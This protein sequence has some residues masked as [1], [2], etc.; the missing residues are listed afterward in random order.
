[1]TNFYIFAPF[2]CKHL[3]TFSPYISAFLNCHLPIFYRI[4]FQTAHLATLAAY[5]RANNQTLAGQ[6]NELYKQYGYH[7]TSNSY[8]LCYEPETI[9]SIFQRIRT[10]DDVQNNVSNSNHSSLLIYALENVLRMH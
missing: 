10:F 2:L 8:F 1:M 9:V 5:L 4:S 3:F 7:F 6:L